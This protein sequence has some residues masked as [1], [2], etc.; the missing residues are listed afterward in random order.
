V[1]KVP[2]PQ[3]LVGV[4]LDRA[5][6]PDRRDDAAA[7][8]STHDE[9]EALDALVSVASDASEAEA[10]LDRCGASIA[11]IWSRNASL[12]A[13]TLER[14]TERARATSLRTLDAL[15]GQSIADETRARD[16]FQIGSALLKSGDHA[17]AIEALESSAALDPRAKTLELLGEAFLLKG[18]PL[19]AVV[20]LAAA[21][22]LS[23]HGR[24]PSLLA[25]ALLALGDN[26]RAHEIARL[27]LTR[28]AGNRKAQAVFEATKAAYDKWSAL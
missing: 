25:E 14:L 11:A 5:V 13:A 3:G 8:L 24:A 21:T 2:Q 4:L 1:T 20:P 28:D 15:Q 16:A 10:L 6:P 19:R 23:T 18:A 22:T 17:G 12:D 9:P 26:V 7:T 27:A